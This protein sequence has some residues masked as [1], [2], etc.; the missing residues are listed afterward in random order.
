LRVSVSRLKKLFATSLCS[1]YAISKQK[2]S[3]IVCFFWGALKQIGNSGSDYPRQDRSEKMGRFCGSRTIPSRHAGEKSGASQLTCKNIYETV[4]VTKSNNNPNA[5][6]RFQIFF[7][8]VPLLLLD[9]L[10]AYS[11]F[12]LLP[13]QNLA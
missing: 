8:I 4:A 12:H 5:R 11:V 9:F 6:L 3:E 1:S 2:T 7:I 10:S 13:V